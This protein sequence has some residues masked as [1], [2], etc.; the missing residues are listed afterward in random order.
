MRS[1]RLRAGFDSVVVKMMVKGM[2]TRS[3]YEIMDSDTGYGSKSRKA[4]RMTPRGNGKSGMTAVKFLNE[5][6][7][8]EKASEIIAEVEREME[9][10]IAEMDIGK[11]IAEDIEDTEVQ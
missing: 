6:V 4:V 7:G 5:A 8:K 10:T 11:D 2:D 1:E 9:K 3:A